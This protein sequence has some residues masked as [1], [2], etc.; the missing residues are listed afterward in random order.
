MAI[1]LAAA[2]GLASCAGFDPPRA[3]DPYLPPASAGPYREASASALVAYGASLA[4]LDAA[5]RAFECQ[6]VLSIYRGDR[7]LPVLFHLF[8][9]QTA[10]PGCGDLRATTRE[11]QAMRAVVTDPMLR[12][13]LTVQILAAEGRVEAAA[14]RQELERALRRARYNLK[15]SMSRHR[16]SISQVRDTYRRMKSRDAEAR[17]LKQRVDELKS[18][19]QGLSQSVR[20]RDAEA[21][22]LKEKLDALKSIEREINETERREDY[23]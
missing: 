7:Q 12:N 1:C 5:G 13:F 9:A 10:P 19:E 11:V 20:S 4:V 21:R 22:Q 15:Q 3:Q 14:E 8:V 18:V 2:F 6:R 16:Q 23:D 17:Q